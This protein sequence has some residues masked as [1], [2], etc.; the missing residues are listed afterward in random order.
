MSDDFI[1]RSLQR[2]LDEINAQQRQVEANIARAKADND[3]YLG[4]EY[5]REHAQ[6]RAT[7]NMIIADY[8]EEMARQT[9]KAPPPQTAEEWRVKSAEKMDWNDA[10]QVAAKSRHGV[11]M[12]AFKR[13]IAEVQARRARGE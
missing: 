6:L 9:P 4:G 5:A 2:Q 8:N 11:D 3:D 1:T 7:R 13:G 12:D 10:Y